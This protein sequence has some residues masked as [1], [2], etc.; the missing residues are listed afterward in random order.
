M[1]DEKYGELCRHEINLLRGQK[2]IARDHKRDK[3]TAIVEMMEEFCE[4]MENKLQAL[5]WIERIRN[6]KPRYIRDQ[7]QSLKV[8]VT[9]L[10]PYIASRALDYACE[11]AILSATDFKAIVETM[12]RK[13]QNE[14]LQGPKIIQLNP[15]SGTSKRIAD[16]D[17]QR[18]DLGSYDAFFTN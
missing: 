6:H 10:D 1:L 5:D 7:I 13:Q 4:L 12:N 17:P 3:N 15:L 9:G 14:V 2:I 16:T 8:T 18:S 11:N